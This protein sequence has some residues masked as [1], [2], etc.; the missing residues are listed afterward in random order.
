VADNRLRESLARAFDRIPPAWRTVTEP[1]RLSAAGQAVAGF[2][3]R[4][5][6][7]G[8]TVYP[9]QV[10]HA[11]DFQPPQATR[12][13]ILGQDPY[14]GPGQACGLAFSLTAG[15]GR[16]PPSL[17]NILK[18]VASDT[19][20]PSICDG[21]LSPWARQGVLLLNTVLTVDDGAPQSHAGRGWE[22]L[23]DA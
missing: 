3:D 18:E 13:V 6:R 9:N 10:F 8:A 20:R 4:R 2:V 21:D 5:I 15:Q 11:L 22:T 16:F 12:V 14:H 23:T 17:R 19:G 1:F 7:D